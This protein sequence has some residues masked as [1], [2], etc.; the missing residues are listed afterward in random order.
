M[1]RPLTA[2]A[3]VPHASALSRLQWSCPIYN[4]DPGTGATRSGQEKSNIFESEDQT[5]KGGLEDWSALL[6]EISVEFTETGRADFKHENFNSCQTVSANDQKNEESIAKDESSNIIEEEVQKLKLGC[7]EVA[8]SFMNESHNDEVQG[9]MFEQPDMPQ[10]LDTEGDQMISD[11]WEICDVNSS[12]KYPSKMCKDGDKNISKGGSH[13]AEPSPPK[14]LQCLELESEYYEMSPRERNTS[15]ELDSRSNVVSG[16]FSIEEW[17]MNRTFDKAIEGLRKLKDDPIQINPGT[18]P[19][20]VQDKK[21][22]GR[23]SGYQNEDDDD[24]YIISPFSET[25]T[26]KTDRRSA[27]TFIS[28]SP[29]SDEGIEVTWPPRDEER[30]RYLAEKFFLRWMETVSSRKKKL[31]KACLF[32]NLNLKVGVFQHWK[33]FVRKHKIERELQEKEKEIQQETIKQYLAQKYRE[34]NLCSRVFSSWLMLAR[35]KQQKKK[36]ISLQEEKESSK[37]KVDDFLQSLGNFKKKNND[38][39]VQKVQK[40]KSEVVANLDIARKV[41]G[42]CKKK[43]ETVESLPKIMPKP[44]SA[45]LRGSKGDETGELQKEIIAAQRKKMREQWKLIEDLKEQKLRLEKNRPLTRPGIVKKIERC[46]PLEPSLPDV[47][48]KKES[49]QLATEICPEGSPVSEIAYSEDFEDCSSEAASI[50]PKTPDLVKRVREREAARAAK[51]EQIRLFHERKVAEERAAAIAKKEAEQQAE[52]EE[53]KHRRDL[54][55]AARREEAERDKRRVEE[56]ERQIRLTQLAHQFHR[57]LTVKQY[58]FRPWLKLIISRKVEGSLAENHHITK[59]KRW[60]DKTYPMLAFMLF[61]V[62][63]L[64]LA[65]TSANNTEGEGGQGRQIP[66]KEVAS[67]L[68]KGDQTKNRSDLTIHPGFSYREAKEAGCWRLLRDESSSEAF[69]AMEP[70]HK[71]REEKALWEHYKGHSPLQT[72]QPPLSCAKTSIEV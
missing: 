55:R 37:K 63:V 61:Q 43:N 52:E 5:K 38:W 57:H 69:G 40:N 44:S 64:R 13:S 46:E 60:V 54:W 24:T 39:V 20:P 59:I 11:A 31:G 25:D 14:R 8:W 27:A 21:D 18:P 56:K 62:C 41:Y 1:E 33:E 68:G 30:E 67:P 9:K 7:L 3:S 17:R 34:R 45:K 32:H 51:R 71:I 72:V 49:P 26:L 2:V 50:V 42:P 19:P 58:G 35:I 70:D 6:D 16:S 10:C 53:R 48:A 28:T 12:I 65:G 47:C 22:H 36:V 23:Q 15:E 29:E 4:Q 66:V